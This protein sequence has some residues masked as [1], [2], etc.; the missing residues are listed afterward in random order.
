M[1]KRQKSKLKNIEDNTKLMNELA[2][3]ENIPDEIL[4]FEPSYEK[5][6][7]TLQRPLYNLIDTTNSFYNMENGLLPLLDITEKQTYYVDVDQEQIKEG[8]EKIKE[9]VDQGF[10]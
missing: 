6:L 3:Y 7:E 1:K 8:L 9:Y 4:Y 2:Q 5:V 10:Q